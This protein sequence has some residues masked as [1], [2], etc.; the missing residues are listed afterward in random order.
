[1]GLSII[2]NRVPEKKQN[3]N[4]GTGLIWFDHCPM[5]ADGGSSGKKFKK[6]CNLLCPGPFIR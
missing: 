4:R 1:M 3:K 2:Y 5:A 6:K